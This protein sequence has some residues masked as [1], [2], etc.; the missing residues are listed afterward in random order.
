M[1]KMQRTN[2]LAGLTV[3]LAIL[4]TGQ[5]QDSCYADNSNPYLNFATKTAYEHAYNKRGISAVPDCK[6][7]QLWLVA[8]HG[9]RWPGADNIPEFQE[10]NQI[11]NHII[12]NYNSNKGSLCLQDIE[13]LKAWTFTLT[14]EMGDMLTVQGKQDLYFMGRRL[15]SYFPE[16][17]SNSVYSPEKFVFRHTDTPRTKESAEYF[18]KGIFGLTIDEPSPQLPDA[19]ADDPLIYRYDNC[20][21][22]EGESGDAK[23]EQKK[24]KKGEFMN[25]V[26]Y[27]VSRRLGFDYNL[28]QDN[29]KTIYDGCRYQK[30]WNV[31]GTSP[32]CAAFS[33]DELEVMEYSED[34]KA[35]YKSG[36]GKSMNLRLA[37]PLVKDMFTRFSN[38]ENR[39]EGDN[40][41]GV[42]YFSHATMVN[43]LSARL[44]LT[45]DIPLTADNFPQQHRRQFRTSRIIPFA[46]NV[47]A[48]LYN[49][50]RGETLQTIIYQVED[51]VRYDGCSVG[52]C[53]WNYLKQLFS[54]V[55]DSSCTDDSFCSNKNSAHVQT[56][57]QLGLLILTLLLSCFLAQ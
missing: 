19:I 40:P 33:K 18:A 36:P 47:L 6:P 48:V 26:I 20:P 21:T 17:L 28:T 4:S 11:K 31:T 23:Q 52:L 34:L 25:R 55:Q 38:V 46:G 1:T 9:T 29:V 50:S 7:V 45:K 32:W 35:Y 39:P 53:E 51:I 15:R 54:F 30:A 10:L 41:I 14:P 3:C 44:S 16:L 12:S 13:N 24:F 49:C 27:N 22:W 57:A 8:R 56:C 43:M 42:F 2:L 5:A 37:C